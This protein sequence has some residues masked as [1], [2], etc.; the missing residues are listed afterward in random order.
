VAVGIYVPTA[1]EG[2]FFPLAGIKIEPRK[3]R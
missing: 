2:A 1:L 3:M